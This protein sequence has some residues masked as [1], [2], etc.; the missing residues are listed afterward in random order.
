[1]LQLGAHPSVI[2]VTAWASVL[3]QHA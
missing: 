2:F 3:K 1:M